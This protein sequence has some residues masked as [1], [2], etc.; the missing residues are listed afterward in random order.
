MMAPDVVNLTYQLREDELYEAHRQLMK[1]RMRPEI[2]VRNII[3][4]AAVIAVCVLSLVF[5][6][7]IPEAAGITL[8]VAVPTLGVANALLL[9]NIAGLM[10]YSRNAK[11]ISKHVTEQLLQ[12]FN[13]TFLQKTIFWKTSWIES[14]VEW[15][16]YIVWESDDF[17]FFCT[18]TSDYLPVPK[19]AF[20]GERE[21]QAFRSFA[22]VSL[23]KIKQ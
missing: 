9:R 11:R 18:E 10:E 15:K 2:F 13:V 23:G 8:V 12:R 19:S 21:M 14:E 5:L 7:P 6:G 4:F 3:I 16:F 20:A 1:L 17:F 22:E